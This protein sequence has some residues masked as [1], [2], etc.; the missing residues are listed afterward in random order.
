MQQKL[1]ITVSG[2]TS[3][4]LKAAI[5]AAGHALVRSSNPADE[6][7]VNF[8]ITELPAAEAQDWLPNT[9]YVVGT[10]A[11]G[12]VIVSGTRSSQDA[13]KDEAI[14][15]AALEYSQAVELRGVSFPERQLGGLFIRPAPPMPKLRS[16]V[17]EYSLRHITDI[18]KLDD[19][20]IPEFVRTLPGLIAMLKIAAA[21]G[22]PN[23]LNLAEEMPVIQFTADNSSSVEVRHAQASVVASAEQLQAGWQRTKAMLPDHG[24]SYQQ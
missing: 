9:L 10:N 7:G 17:Q 14:M 4:E 8:D 13:A 20:D 3:E 11:L 6:A 22:T 2:D 18:A 24:A 19:A 21:D 23:G 1:V 15:T 16:E 5:I 12:E